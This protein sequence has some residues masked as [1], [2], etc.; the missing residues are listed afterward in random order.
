MTKRTLISFVG[1]ITIISLLILNLFNI[2]KDGKYAQT[3]NSMATNTIET[4]NARG[5]ILDC[6]MIPLVNIKKK[7]VAVINPTTEA[8]AELSRVLTK[9]EMKQIIEYYRIGKPFVFEMDTKNI[10]CD[11][12][13]LIETSER[14]TT[15]QLAPHIIGYLDASKHEGVYAIEKAYNDILK[16][17]SGI[18]I[19]YAV[20]ANGRALPG[21]AP[22]VSNIWD[23]SR[24]VL[25]L[26]SNIQLA[27]QNVLKEN[28]KAGA[29]VV[30]DITNGEIKAVVSVPD[31]T[32][33]NLGIALKNSDSPFINRAFT[34]YNVGSVFKLVSVCAALENKVSPSYDYTCTGSISV[35]DL[36]FNCHKFDGH[37]GIDMQK[38]VEQSCNTYFIDLILSLGGDKL[39]DMAGTLGFGRETVFAPDYKS[40]GGGLP[41]RESFI[42]PAAVGNFAFG[43]GDLMATPVQ[44]ANLM[45]TICSKGEMGQL[46]LVKETTD[47]KGKTVK[48]KPHEKTR[49]L[50]EDTAQKIMEYMKSVVESGTGMTAKPT[51]VTAAGKT[52]TA[53]TGIIKDNREVVQ[54]WFAGFFPYENPK[55]AIV[56]ITEDSEN[57]EGIKAAPIFK[58]IAERIAE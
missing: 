38:A 9:E 29:A 17:S 1:F 32:P 10:H 41:N 46:S 40:S 14:Y 58:A 36:S 57:S 22:E 53:Q 44:M 56:V 16:N 8:L 34:S 54:S 24:V 49:V 12:I 30:A 28:V 21:I 7:T 26:D 27:T 51:N 55:Y 18:K 37:G 11:D 23:K 39:L 42:N 31:F 6:N 25:T 43:Q 15:Y 48:I 4:G 2:I 52:A 3:G 20:D 5:E 47:N 13:L 33:D 45:Y 19:T 50:S 35:K